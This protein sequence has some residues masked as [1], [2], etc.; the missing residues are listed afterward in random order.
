MESKIEKINRMRKIILKVLLLGWVTLGIWLFYRT[1]ISVLK[2]S[3]RRIDVYARSIEPFVKTLWIVGAIILAIYV[4]IYLVY[5]AKITKDSSVRTAVNDE[6][7]RLNWLKAFRI[8]FFTLLFITIF[9][10][11]AET[12]LGTSF[13]HRKI[14]PI[15]G[16]WLMWYGSIFALIVSFLYYDREVKNE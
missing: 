3:W 7:V 15:P 8:A 10:K 14:S 13:L 4:I 11:W 2:L 9:W 1:I 6:R 12:G 5:K 16:T